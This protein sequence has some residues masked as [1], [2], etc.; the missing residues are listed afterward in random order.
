MLAHETQVK[1]EEPGFRPDSPRAT[2]FIESF[3][4]ATIAVYPSIIRRTERTAYSYESRG[5]IIA[6][7]NGNGTISTIV[8][9]SRIDMGRIVG[10]S[11]WGWFQDGIQ[12]VAREVRRKARDVDYSLVM[13]FVFPPDNRYV[14]GVHVFILDRAGENAFSFLLNSHHGS[15]VD[16]DLVA[17]DSSEAAHTRV[18]E[19]A[20]QLG[21]AALRAQVDQVRDCMGREEV[22]SEVMPLGIFDDFESGLP[23]GTSESGVPLGFSTF[24]DGTSKVSISTT[25]SY[26][27]RAGDA[28]D[29][30]VLRLDLKVAD[31]AGFIHTFEDEE[32]SAWKSYDWSG[33]GEFSFWLYGQD[34]GTSLFVDILDNRRACSTVDDAERFGYTFIDN[35]AGWRRIAIRFADMQRKEIYNNAPDDGFTLSE[36]H[37]WAFGAL[38]TNGKITLYVD[39]V[40][41]GPAPAARGNYPINEL[42]MYGHLTKTAAQKRADKKYIEYAT[43]GGRSREHAADMAAKAGWNY[44]Y[45][46]DQPTAIKRFNQ[47]WMLDPE[48]PL[49]LWGFAGICRDRDQ[50]DDAIRY[51]EMAI[52]K[53]PENILLERDYQNTVLQMR[54]REHALA[55]R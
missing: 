54:Q 10:R 24:S 27:S 20:T 22:R 50:M 39:H 6:S 18:I 7:L 11:Q 23:A 47:A 26:R 4:T 2:A 45:K 5:Q 13:E 34:S 55:T 12:A 35:F 37:G 42:P 48:N 36:V 33:A 25:T 40:G 8:A 9:N 16:A 49:A 15:F 38:N 3:D 14:F 51:F 52:E 29:N 21:L 1:V 28:A 53:D 31:W 44:Y 19:K 17:E 30:T 43:S 41:L 32:V 46:G